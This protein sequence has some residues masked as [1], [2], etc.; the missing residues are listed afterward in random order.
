MQRKKG[1][2]EDQKS[3]NPLRKNAKKKGTLDSRCATRF[4]CGAHVRTVSGKA[5]SVFREKGRGN[6]KEDRQRGKKNHGARRARDY[7]GVGGSVRKWMWRRKQKIGQHVCKDQRVKEKNRKRGSGGREGIRKV[8]KEAEGEE[9]CSRNRKRERKREWYVCSEGN[10]QR[11]A[12]GG[13][14]RE[15][16]PRETEGASGRARA[17]GVEYTDGSLVAMTTTVA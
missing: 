12:T 17:R 15:D 13:T 3:I 9:R 2:F 6:E 1:I 8:E 10:R 14:A 4:C 16:R 7:E 11:G 5:N